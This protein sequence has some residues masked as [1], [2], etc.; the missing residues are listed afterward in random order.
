MKSSRQRRKKASAVVAEDII[1]S[2]SDLE[3]DRIP[4]TV[5]VEKLSA[6]RRRVL[7]E[8][9][10]ITVTTESDTPHTD[11]DLCHDFFDFANIGTS[12]SDAGVGKTA[13]PANAETRKKRYISSK[14]NGS[15][16]E[17]V[18]LQSMGLSIQLGHKP[19]EKCPN[20][21]P[22]RSKLVVL[23][24]N[25]IHPTSISYCGCDRAVIAGNVR[26]QLLRYQLYPA[27]E[28][29]PM[30]CSTFTLL[31]TI[32]LQNVQAK[33]GVYDLYSALERMSDNTGL[34]PTRDCYKAFARSVREWKHLKMLKRAGRGHD[35]SGIPGTKPGDLAVI[36]P[37]CPH[38]GINLPDDWDNV[39][40]ADKFLY[41]LHVSLDACFRVKRFAVSDEIK[42]PIIDDGL[43][44]FVEET[45]YKAEIAK[46]KGQ[47]PMGSCTGL[48]ALDHADS[49]FHNGYAAT[50]VGACID[51][52]HEFMLPTSVGDLQVGE[53]FVNMDFVWASALRHFRDVDP[54]TMY[55]IVC[56]WMTYLGQRI[57]ELP[58]EYRP[59]RFP[60][61]QELMWAI[62]KLHWYSHKAADHSR[63]SLNF[64]PGAGR[65]DGEGIERRWWIMQPITS[66]TK[67]MGP[68]SRQGTLNDQF[69]FMNW[70]NLVK[71]GK[72]PQTLRRLPPAIDSGLM[73]YLLGDTLCKKYLDVYKNAAI[74]Q[75]DFEMLSKSIQL[76]TRKE[77]EDAVRKWENDLSADDPYFAE[78]NG[79]SE[80]AIR[81][82]LAEEEAEQVRA[83]KKI[84]LHDVSPAAFL[85]IGLELEEQ[86]RQLRSEASRNDSVKVFE[87]R[88]A[89]TRRVLRF[90]EVQSVYMPKVP[91]ILATG[92]ELY[93][94]SS[95][96]GSSPISTQLIEN[97]S[98][99]LP[100]DLLKPYR[101][102]L[103]TIDPNTISPADVDKALAA[104]AAVLAGLSAGLVAQEQQ[105]RAAQCNDALDSLRTKV[106]M[107]SGL[108]EYKRIN[109][110]HQGPNT[111]AR[112]LFENLERR[113]QLSANKYRAARDALWSLTGGGE[114]WEKSFSGRYR[115]LK[116][117]DIRALEDDDPT[118]A[119]RRKKQRKGPAEGRRVSS[120]IWWGS[121]GPQSLNAG[122][123]VEWLKARARVNRWKE[124]K[125]L[126]PEEMRR[127]VAYLNWK[128]SQWDTRG[129]LRSDL[130]PTL[131]AGVRAYAAKQSAICR[132]LA[133][134]FS[135]SWQK[136]LATIAVLEK[137]AAADDIPTTTTGAESTQDASEG[138]TTRARNSE[139]EHDRDEDNDDDG[140]VD[141]EDVGV[142]DLG[143]DE[144]VIAFM[145]IDDVLPMY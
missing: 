5:T 92:A 126:L 45:P 14:W 2:M 3:E 119:H 137:A 34:L 56:H 116:P 53:R 109:V 93:S 49:K 141:D 31:E 117:E 66:S 143:E 89:L 82:K 100:S 118:T 68:G 145:E 24:T 95:T 86:Q 33:S 99:L 28:Q 115:E 64:I 124:E 72:S 25:G 114:E 136:T 74:Q 65:S 144:A 58:P 83:G 7:R 38:P 23:H 142:Q 79:P 91:Q 135:N 111:R 32:H 17:K 113:I 140:S 1:F 76:K 80:S 67:M 97:A 75:T 81:R 40:E 127:S 112:G 43:A 8:D 108:R 71:L 47:K 85:S 139:A 133:V 77:W 36:C 138:P 132:G 55:D 57:A 78:E 121:E 26:Q 20:P 69:G 73:L 105:M 98:L 60:S 9:A 120:W 102:N 129:T 27:T 54:M 18:T 21:T 125:R 101:L 15:Y 87:S 90:R 103:A 29:E 10:D 41:R 48:A 107:R 59:S 46:Y 61:E 106:H 70:R 128:A 123:R 131:Q 63:Y 37:A 30:T 52:R 13:E 94:P 39:P 51:A 110:R 44:Y 6:D 4:T 42:D 130:E 50:G 16:F 11:T 96:P 12:T 84:P 62:G 19:G 122:V 35:P 22:A 88:T 134:K 104:R